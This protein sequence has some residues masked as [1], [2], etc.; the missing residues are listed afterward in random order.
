MKTIDLLTEE[1]KRLSSQ[2][3]QTYPRPQ[4]RRDSFF[5]LNGLWEFCTSAAETFPDAY[6]RQIRV[7]FAPQ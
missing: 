5:N 2:P 3:W 7:P 1:G 4:M 6:D